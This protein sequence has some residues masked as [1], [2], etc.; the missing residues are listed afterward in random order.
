[1]K[2]SLLF[3]ASLILSMSVM[4]DS[5]AADSTFAAPAEFSQ[6]MGFRLD[7]LLV[8]AAAVVGYRLVLPNGDAENYPRLGLRQV[9]F[10][11]VSVH[12]FIRDLAMAAGPNY[13]ITVDVP[14]K[15]IVLYSVKSESPE[16][17]Q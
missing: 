3:L 13:H 5:S 1:M 17:S 14:E 11:D 16:L 12:D 6:E 8:E 4:A 10:G 15:A 7:V 9:T 2:K